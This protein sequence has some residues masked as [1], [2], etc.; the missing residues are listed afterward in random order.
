M[1]SAER[2]V[3]VIMELLNDDTLAAPVRLKVAQDVLDRQG[4]VA[5]HVVK[6]LPGEHDPVAT[7]FE[8]LLQRPDALEPEH[9]TPQLPAPRLDGPVRDEDGAYLG[10]YVGADLFDDEPD[11]EPDVVDA[12]IVP[13]Q[14]QV[15][16]VPKHVNDAVK[17]GRLR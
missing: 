16:P 8:A 1:Y 15:L 3:E 5:A 9:E 14:P 12:E 10:S 7:L 11:A 2:A 6:I 13:P 17:Q 4:L